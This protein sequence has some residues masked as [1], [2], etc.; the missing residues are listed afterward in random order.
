MFP[1]QTLYI[2]QVCRP[3]RQTIRLF[4][5]SLSISLISI[6]K[7]KKPDDGGGW[8]THQFLSSLFF[9]SNRPIGDAAAA[10]S[11]SWAGDLQSRQPASVA[12]RRGWRQRRLRLGE[13]QPSQPEEEGFQHLVC[14]PRHLPL[15][16]GWLRFSHRPPQTRTTQTQFIPPFNKVMMISITN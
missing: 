8:N 10:A 5:C 11:G 2:S 15:H 4:Y 7:G 3:K 12:G 6:L 9:K 16:Q 1:T 13:R 14:C